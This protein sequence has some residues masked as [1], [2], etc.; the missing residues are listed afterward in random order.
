MFLQPHFSTALRKASAGI[1]AST[2]SMAAHHVLH[3]RGN[4]QSLP[5][6]GIA[7]EGCLLCC[8]S[9]ADLLHVVGVHLQF[10]LLLHRLQQLLRVSSFLLRRSWSQQRRQL[11]IAFVFLRIFRSSFPDDSTILREMRP[12][13][14]ITSKMQTQCAISRLIDASAASCRG[15]MLEMRKHCRS[16]GGGRPIA[17]PER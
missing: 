3:L 13:K 10:F 12:P 17:A 15:V 2:F 1:E 16:P 8:R 11:I 7:G 5:G 9:A 6:A 4:A 14:L